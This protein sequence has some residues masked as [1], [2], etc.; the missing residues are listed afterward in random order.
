[1]TWALVLVLWAGTANPIERQIAERLTWDE[2]VARALLQ[3]PLYQRRYS[4]PIGLRCEPFI[5][6]ST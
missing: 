3:T 4:Y 5:G 1:M 2:C 6:T